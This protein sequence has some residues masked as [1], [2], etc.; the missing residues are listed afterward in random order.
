[1]LA[2]GNGFRV[3]AVAGC[4]GVVAKALEIKPDVVIGACGGA[5]GFDGLAMLRQL[6]GHASTRAIPVILIA[7]PRI[8]PAQAWSA[9]VDAIVTEPLDTVGLV[10]QVHA[11]VARRRVEEIE[12]R[13][14]REL[15]ESVA[16]LID[17]AIALADAA[18]PG[19]SAHGDAVGRL[20][21]RLAERFAVPDEFRRDLILAA[22]LHAIAQPMLSGPEPAD[23]DPAR[24]STATAAEL[25]VV[26]VL[27]DASDLVASSGEHWDGTGRP[28]GLQ[29]GQIPLRARIIRVAVD[30]VNAAARRPEL[31]LAGAIPVLRPHTGTHYDPAV[32]AEAESVAEDNAWEEEGVERLVLDRLEPG[33][34]LEEDLVTASGVKLLARGGVL[35]SASLA[36]VARRHVTDPIVHALKIRR[37]RP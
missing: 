23:P 1:L 13:R 35:T 7:G 16:R 29:R 8:S 19:L 33:M 37:P 20:A 5:D 30:L 15:E 31:G 32:L 24:L 27:C 10:A 2:V 14:V 6:R 17:L 25:R 22:R 18:T 21:E 9:G 26:P 34:L 3:D 28:A 11:L 36:A 12:Q 4:Q